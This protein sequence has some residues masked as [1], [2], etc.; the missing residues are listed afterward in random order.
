[1]MNIGGALGMYGFAILTQR[2]GRK[3]AF[4][5]CFLAAFASTAMVFY[6][7]RDFEQIFWMLPVMGFC[8]FSLFAGYAVYFPELFPTYLRSTGTS[9]CY[10]VGRF[11]AA[12]GPFMLGWL[13][14]HLYAESAE[15]LRYAGLTMC[16]IF[17]IGLIVLPFAPE[18][19]DKPLPE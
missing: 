12:V 15:P 18:T 17:V 16:G 3:P 13:T 19:K 8:V 5:L 2:M 6:W 9:F 7:L 1:M 11:V 14:S 4:A 10:N